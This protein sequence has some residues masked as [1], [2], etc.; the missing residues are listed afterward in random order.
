MC[1]MVTV[2]DGFGDA[3]DLR[4][5]HIRDHHPQPLYSNHSMA[6]S[7]G[8]FYRSPALTQ[9]G[10]TPLSSEGRDMGGSG[11]GTAKRRLSRAPR[12]FL[13]PGGRYPGETSM[14]NWHN[15]GTHPAGG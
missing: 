5:R 13:L 2:F 4:R 10:W 1:G 9:G 15:A 8:A 14:V 6:D 12:M 7:L 11:D 3:K